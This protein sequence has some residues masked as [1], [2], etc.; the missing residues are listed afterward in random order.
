MLGR[1]KKVRKI[2]IGPSTYPT[3]KNPHA[4]NPIVTETSMQRL[5]KQ[6]LATITARSKGPKIRE[7]FR[8]LTPEFKQLDGYGPKTIKV[9][10][11]ALTANTVSKNNRLYIDE[12]L[13]RAA[14]TLRGKPITV[15]HDPNRII[16]HVEV[17]EYEDGNLEF[18][19][20]IKKEPYVSMLR[21]N[22][23]R[24]RGLSIEGN[25]FYL[26]CLYCGE[27]FYNEEEFQRHMAEEH[28]IRNGVGQV[29]G[30][31]LDGLSLVLSPET[32]GVETTKIEL[33]EMAKAQNRIFEIILKEKAEMKKKELKEDER[34]PKEWWD[35]CI[36]YMHEH[37]PEYSDEQAAAVCGYIYYHVPHGK[38]AT[39]ETLDIRR[40]AEL[41][42]AEKVEKIG[43]KW[44][45]VHCHGPDAGKPIKCFDS[46]EE[47]EAMHRAIMA[48]KAKA[49]EQE[50]IAPA[51]V[52]PI[53]VSAPTCPEGYVYDPVQQKCVPTAEMLE[54]I[55]KQYR[56]FKHVMGNEIINRLK[57]LQVFNERLLQEIKN[58]KETQKAIE[59]KQKEIEQRYEAVENMTKLIKPLSD[60]FQKLNQRIDM[61]ETVHKKS[62]KES[63]SLTV[64]LDN[65]ESR[66]QGNF[67]GYSKPLNP[68]GSYVP[69]NPHL[70]RER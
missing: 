66:L 56:L 12:E 60:G 23:P 1:R 43:D 35:R 47:A 20:V 53:D 25:Y 4:E 44:C 40:I 51:T 65:L 70:E 26:Q 37:M 67:K 17:A 24:I 14:R 63:E 54:E 41:A 59:E 42:L 36:A 68:E 39:F 30:L 64:R 32:P 27:K 6:R 22:D 33:L 57:T 13:R 28:L 10:G 49:E 16:G 61:L 58:L 15:N 55:D 3:P 21:E 29:Y 50:Q 45:V 46:K 19:G 38:S 5:E 52:S 8:W 11:I 18:I 69:R 31:H 62:L 48:N 9:K 2:R 34:P 7:S